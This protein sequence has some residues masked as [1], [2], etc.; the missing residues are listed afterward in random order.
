[1]R[2]PTESLETQLTSIRKKTKPVQI[3]YELITCPL[4]EAEFGIIPMEEFQITTADNI[5]SYTNV[6]A[7]IVGLV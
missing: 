1:M 6:Q 3:L 7:N 4:D 2:V 5:Q